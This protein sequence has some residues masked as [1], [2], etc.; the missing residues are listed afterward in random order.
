MKSDT[1]RIARYDAKSVPANVAPVVTAQLPTMKSGFS[2]AVQSLYAI[3]AAIQNELNGFVVPTIQYP[4][5]L[6]FGREIWALMRRGISGDTLVAMAQSL[7]EKYVLYGLDE[8]FLIALANG[9][10]TLTLT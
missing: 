3:E 2:S 9:V 8:N 5:Y 10:F 4:F 7:Q 1:Q 6:N